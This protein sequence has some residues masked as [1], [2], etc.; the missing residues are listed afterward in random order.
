MRCSTSLS[1]SI[2]LLARGSRTSGHS[3]QDPK[4]SF[5]FSAPGSIG[6][7]VV[8]NKGREVRCGVVRHV[9]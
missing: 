8:E 9:E 4:S 5:A 7:K 2:N 1:V 3:F 6:N